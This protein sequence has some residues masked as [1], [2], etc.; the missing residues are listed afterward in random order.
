[1]SASFSASASFTPSPVIATTWP[2]C[3]SAADDR[4]LLVRRD[5]AEHAEFASSTLAEL[6]GVVGELAGVDRASA[7]AMPTRAATAPTVRGLSPEMTLQRHALVAEVADRL[8]GVVADLLLE[9]H[10]RGR[11]EPVG[12]LLADE[13]GIARAPSSSTRRPSLA[14][15]VGL[16]APDRSS[17]RPAHTISGAPSTHVP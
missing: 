1:M 10:E 14:S 12:Q 16:R 7:P 5:P 15:L 2:R 8:G 6:V 3:C 9:Q 11:L 4:P 17:G 13:R